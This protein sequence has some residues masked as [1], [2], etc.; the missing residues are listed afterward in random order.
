[1]PWLSW[2]KH[3]IWKPELTQSYLIIGKDMTYKVTDT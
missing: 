2:Y 1:M 3:L